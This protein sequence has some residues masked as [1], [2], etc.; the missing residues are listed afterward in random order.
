MSE[1]YQMREYTP[2]I[3]KLY[4]S[5]HWE[6]EKLI[7]KSNFK[8]NFDYN[9]RI[10]LDVMLYVIAD[11]LAFNL[12]NR[13]LTGENLLPYLEIKD[14]WN[15]RI[16]K[17]RIE[18]YGKIIRKSIKLRGN[19]LPFDL[20][21]NLANNPL[22]RCAI[23]FC[24]ILKTPELFSD[25]VFASFVIGGFDKDVNFA[26]QVVMPIIDIIIDYISKIT[27]LCK[28][29]QPQNIDDDDSSKL[30]KVVL[31]ILATIAITIMYFLLNR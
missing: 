8:H 13:E 10:D 16:V 17:S 4:N 19:C 6:I 20:P 25:Y 23:A 9:L 28:T 24:D 18:F 27:E 26:T 5:T 12:K 29:T 11:F 31:G 21:T 30:I 1:R 3:V 15:S 7:N 14:G 2:E 22:T